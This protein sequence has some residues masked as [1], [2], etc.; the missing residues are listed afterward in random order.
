MTTTL[1]LLVSLGTVQLLRLAAHALL[2]RAGL[3]QLTAD[4]PSTSPRWLIRQLQ[5]VG[6]D[7]QTLHSWLDISSTPVALSSTLAS[8]LA[9]LVEMSSSKI[10]EAP[11]W[12][13]VR[14]LPLLIVAVLSC[15]TPLPHLVGSTADAGQKLISLLIFLVL[16][17]GPASGLAASAQGW[18]SGAL[19]A[20]SVV[21]WIGFAQMGMRETAKDSQCVYLPHPLPLTGSRCSPSIRQHL[22][23]STGLLVPPLL[24]SHELGAAFRSGHFGFFT[25]GGFLIQELLMAWCGLANLLVFWGLLRV[26]F[27]RSA[28]QV[29]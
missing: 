19:Y 26:R 20:G 28:E 9:A 3:R 15:T 4:A 2:N 21:G 1:H 27:D 8:V 14:L 11:F 5:R 10:T 25:S 6:G 29:D 12:T 13:T 24:L 16:L 23:L 7:E 17:G 22:L 18:I